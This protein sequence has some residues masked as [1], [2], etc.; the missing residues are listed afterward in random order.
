MND[1]RQFDNI[2]HNV[3]DDLKEQLQK[4]GKVGVAAA[5]FSIYAYEALKA[6]ARECAEWIREKA[7]FKSNVSGGMMNGFLTCRNEEDKFVYMPFNEF[8]TTELG[9]ER[10]NNLCPTSIRLAS[11]MSDK[12]IRDFNELWQ[13]D[14]QFTDVTEQIIDNISNVY[15]ENAPEF[16]YFI[17][18]F[19]IFKEFLDDISEDVLPNEATG[20]KSSKV[21][22]KLTVPALLLER[23]SRSFIY[24]QCS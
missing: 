18:L 1:I 10:G 8:P 12:Y 9:L 23:T 24:W 15:K 21:W 13:D 22:N 19:N 20:F 3:A 17:T 4:G 6:I 16:I 11:P 14:T 2:I 7:K 5:C